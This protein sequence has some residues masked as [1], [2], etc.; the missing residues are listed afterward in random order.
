MLCS[1]A[2]PYSLTFS[3]FD[4][5]A[6]LVLVSAQLQSLVFVHFLLIASMQRLPYVQVWLIGVCAW[7]M[8]EQVFV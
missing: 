2:I 3:L 8:V 5:E 6:L 4:L 1:T 7:I